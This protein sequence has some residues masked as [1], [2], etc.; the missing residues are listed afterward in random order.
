MNY[1][2]HPDA[3]KELEEAAILDTAWRLLAEKPVTAVTIEEL[4]ARCGAGSEC[5]GCWPALEAL[6][7]RQ[8]RGELVTAS[9]GAPLVEESQ[10]TLWLPRTGNAATQYTLS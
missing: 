6:L 1:S 8:V 10:G 4:A 3:E 2:F 9:I 7:D 5:G